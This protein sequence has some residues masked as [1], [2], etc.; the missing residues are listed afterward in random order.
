MTSSWRHHDVTIFFHIAQATIQTI[1]FKTCGRN[2]P[3][4]LYFSQY[5]RYKIGQILSLYGC[6][7]VWMY[8]YPN[9]EISLLGAWQVLVEYTQ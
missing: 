7:D 1:I 5:K 4:L 9:I 3:Y 6:M 2:R 8:L